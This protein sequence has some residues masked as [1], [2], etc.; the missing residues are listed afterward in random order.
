MKFGMIVLHI[1]SPRPIR[2]RFSTNRVKF[3]IGCHTFKMA[4]MTSFYAEK[5]CHLV[6]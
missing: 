1:N 6:S 5:C 2:V 3:L 4:V